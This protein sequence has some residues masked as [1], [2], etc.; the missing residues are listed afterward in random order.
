MLFGLIEEEG[1]RQLE[2]VA[3]TGGSKQIGDE[4]RE[5]DRKTDWQKGESE[6]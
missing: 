5:S 3:Y 6:L 2:R 4:Q 1:Q